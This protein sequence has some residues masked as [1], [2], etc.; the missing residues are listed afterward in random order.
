[1]GR[2]YQFNPGSASGSLNVR[3]SVVQ[4]PQ[5]DQKDESESL[6]SFVV[7]EYEVCNRSDMFN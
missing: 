5:K 3:L 7:H 6:A 4:S 1:M 2:P